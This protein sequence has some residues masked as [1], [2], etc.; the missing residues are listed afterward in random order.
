MKISTG[1]FFTKDELNRVPPPRARADS[2]LKLKMTV[3]PG[4]RDPLS[5][6]KKKKKKIS[7]L[8]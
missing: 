6:A 8:P 1:M 2:Q 3:V 4:R 5:V 7:L